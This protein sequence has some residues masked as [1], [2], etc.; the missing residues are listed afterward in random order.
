M[1]LFMACIFNPCLTK[2]NTFLVHEISSVFQRR[3]SWSQYP[4]KACYKAGYFDPWL[5]PFLNIFPKFAI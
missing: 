1:F 3:K 2:L 5:Q 4:Y